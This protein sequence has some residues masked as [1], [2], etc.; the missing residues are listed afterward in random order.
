MADR[1]LTT[2][3]GS[4]PRTPEILEA[5]R[6]VAAGEITQEEFREIQKEN[7]EWVVKKQREIGIDIV[8]D[9]EYGH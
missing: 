5:N 2:H 3:V 1:I 8:N 4:L 7:V 6:S 9:G